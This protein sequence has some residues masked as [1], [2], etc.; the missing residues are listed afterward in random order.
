MPGRLTLL[1]MMLPL[2]LAAT[3]AR[4]GL[5]T[6]TFTTDVKTFSCRELL[7]LEEARQNLALTY[8]SGFVDGQRNRVQFDSNARGQVIEKV[9]EQCRRD[10]AGS[11][12]DAFLRLTP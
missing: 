6:W 8:F 9:M 5:E 4:A 10:G 2:A 12:L 3:P 11:V 7:A 1:L